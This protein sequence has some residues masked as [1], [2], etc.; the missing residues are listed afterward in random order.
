MLQLEFKE[1]IPAGKDDGHLGL[2]KIKW[3]GIILIYKMAVK[4]GTTIPFAAAS[5]YKTT[6]PITMEDKYLQAFS[7]DSRDEDERVKAFALSHGKANLKMT[8]MSNPNAASSQ[9]PWPSQSAPL[10]YS[11]PVEQQVNLPF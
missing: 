1:F 3:N 4:K 5:S 8:S 2:V 10:Q 11:H 9:A 6:D 7:I